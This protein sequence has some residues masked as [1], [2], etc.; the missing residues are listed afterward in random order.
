MFFHMTLPRPRAPLAP[1]AWV[2]AVALAVTLFVFRAAHADVPAR[3][4]VVVEVDGPAADVDPTKLRADIAR[5]LEEDAV[6]PDDPRATQ[7]RGAL[8]IVVDRDAHKLVVSYRARATPITRAV[9]LPG[10]AVA[11]AR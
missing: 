9:D 1:P 2:V 10:D 7:A 5:D 3:S 4:V 8:Q 11:I 6:P